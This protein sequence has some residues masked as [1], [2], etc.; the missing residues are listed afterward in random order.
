MDALLAVDGKLKRFC[1]SFFVL[2]GNAAKLLE[3]IDEA[4]STAAF[5]R[6]PAVSIV[7]GLQV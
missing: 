7:A 4:L 6:M 3:L 2:S 1:N 5:L